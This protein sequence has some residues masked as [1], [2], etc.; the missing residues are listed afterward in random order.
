MERVEYNLDFFDALKLVLSG[1]AVKGENFSKGYYLTMNSCGQLVTKDANNY[2]K[3][4]D[5]VS[6]DSL[7]RQK[8]RE[9]TVMTPKELEK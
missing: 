8:F 3:E 9:L 2:Y 7:Q 6:V 1:G 4:C 5:F